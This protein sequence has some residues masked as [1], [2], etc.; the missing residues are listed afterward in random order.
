MTR[1][2]T[3]DQLVRMR[4]RHRGYC[5]LLIVISLVLVLQPLAVTWPLLTSIN[6]IVVA[7]V[8]MLFLT[9]YSP[10]RARK[11]W[12]Y[13]LGMGAIV[14]ELIWLASLA[15]SPAL[16]KHLTLPH[17]LI[18]SLFIA[19]F[20]VRKVRVLMIEP[21]V[22]LGVLLGAAAGYLLI[23]YLG[24]FL[25]HSLLIFHPLG[26]NLAYLP[27]G[28]NPVTEPL[29]AF[30]SMV[31]ASFEALTTMSNAISSPGHLQSRIATLMITIVGQLYV[32][33]LIGLVLSRFHQRTQK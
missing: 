32:A 33:V 18:W 27:A 20:L 2:L 24:A 7:L 22:T 25:L 29:R 19:F 23:G 28:I 1:V 30:P 13:G 6:A 9:R 26:F 31:T 10:L 21:Y 17:L 11:R 3:K 4:K 16:A 15:D 5:Y 12:L 8:M 14:F